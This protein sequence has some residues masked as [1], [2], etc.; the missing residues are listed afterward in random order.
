MN[1]S[2][3]EDYLYDFI[4]YLSYLKNNSPI[5]YNININDYVNKYKKV[6]CSAKNDLD[7][8]Y[9]L[10]LF[11]FNNFYGQNGPLLL[12]KP[13]NIPNN[14]NNKCY[15]EIINK[16]KKLKKPYDDCMKYYINEM[17]QY[18]KIQN[19]NNKENKKVYFTSIIKNDKNKDVMMIKI[20]QMI[21]PSIK[22][23]NNLYDFLYKNQSLPELY[24]DVRGNNGGNKLCFDFLFNLIFERSLKLYN[25]KVEYFYKYTD[26]NKPFIDNCLKHCEK[27]IKKIKNKKFTHSYLQITK[28]VLDYPIKSKYLKN[29]SNEYINKKS[30]NYKGNIFIII[31][32]NSMNETQLML[33]FSKGDKQITIL[34]NMRSGGY[35]IINNFICSFDNNI[36]LFLLPKTKICCQYELFYYDYNK[37]VVY[38]DKEIPKWIN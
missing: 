35:G 28:E 2:I 33:D 14:M 25:N 20:P 15:L 19:K 11:Y 12:Y 6:V 23:F 31:D 34:G 10:Q 1:K 37:D 26:F 24:I 38:P 16:M 4:Y 18:N 32:N 7:F 8:L 13:I 36:G 3:N 17:K 22:E 29:V 9:N 21:L 30:I 27:N 5:F